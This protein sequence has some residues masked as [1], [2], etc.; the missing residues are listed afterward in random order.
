MKINKILVPTDFSPNAVIAINFA[1]SFAKNYNCKITLLNI[2][3]VPV[4]DPNMPA[5]MINTSYA[6]LSEISKEQLNK[7][8]SSIKLNDPEAGNCIEKCIS[9][10]GTISDEISN[11]AEEEK[12]DMIIMG[13]TGASGIEETI[14]GSNASSVISR[15]SIPVLS[16]PG[17]SKYK[18]IEKAVMPVELDGSEF[19]TI[20]SVREMLPECAIYPVHF[21]KK[22]E[23]LSDEKQQIF[24]KL[25]SSLKENESAKIVISEDITT[26]LDEILRKYNCDL[27]ITSTVKRSI[28]E[29]LFHKS[30]T[31]K[32]VCHTHV[33][34][35]ALHKK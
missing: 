20:N 21:I 24:E 16:I 14:I 32:L 12:Y 17:E 8:M 23:K 35:L 25:Q 4:Y 6:R 34:L 22:N 9:K 2:Y 5:E 10:M 13:T 31:K 26:G 30:I 27:V 3:S 15:S 28:F 33:P 29:K 11:T 1:L 18:E 7:S 19:N